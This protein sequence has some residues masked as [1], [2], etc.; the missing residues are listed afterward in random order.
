LPGLSRL[1]PAWPRPLWAV[2]THADSGNELTFTL[3]WVPAKA[4]TASVRQVPARSP[5]TA[6]SALGPAQG[7]GGQ[8]LATRFHTGWAAS[9]L[10]VWLTGAGMILLSVA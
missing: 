9:V 2:G 8:R 6:N 3:E 10:V 7:T 4:T 1:L 5:T